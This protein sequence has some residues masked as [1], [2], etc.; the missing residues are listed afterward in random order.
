MN[1]AFSPF[2]KA[3]PVKSFSISNDS[4]CSIVK[5]SAV[6]CF[7]FSSP[8]SSFITFVSDS[9][10]LPFDAANTAFPDGISAEQD[11]RKASV[12]ASHL[13]FLCFNC[14]APFLLIFECD[15]VFL[16]S[17]ILCRAFPYVHMLHLLSSGS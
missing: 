3:S 8:F 13:C 7:S 6:V 10:T 17:R 5:V 14:N 9:A 11:K 1:T 2:F 12:P 16:F 15:C 4:P